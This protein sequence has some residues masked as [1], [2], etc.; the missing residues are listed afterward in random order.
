MMLYSRSRWRGFLSSDEVRNHVRGTTAKVLRAIG[1]TEVIWLPDWFLNDWP[2]GAVLTI[3]NVQ[4]RLLAEWGLPQSS[5][6]SIEDAV[7]LAAEHDACRW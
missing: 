4:S 2:E 6:D 3:D 1:A 5:L 7:V